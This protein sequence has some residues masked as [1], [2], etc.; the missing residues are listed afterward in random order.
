MLKKTTWSLEGTALS[1]LHPLT[2]YS[3]TKV[4]VSLVWTMSC[5]VTM[6]ACLSCF[7][8]DASRIAV[9]GVPSSSWS[10]ISFN[11]TTCCV[12]LPNKRKSLNW[13]L[14]SREIWL[15]RIFKC[16]RTIPVCHWLH[17]KSKLWAHAVQSRNNTQLY[18]SNFMQRLKSTHTHR[19]RP[20]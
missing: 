3:K 2:T 17:H 20:N 7:S 12:K 10:R 1:P 6:L 18:S 16:S 8:K 11:A 4:S 19:V 9:K 5:S 14:F 15:G 13:E